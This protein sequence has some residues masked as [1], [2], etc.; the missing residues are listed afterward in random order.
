MMMMTVMTVI[1]FSSFIINVLAQQLFGRLQVQHSNVT[2]CTANNNSQ[3]QTHRKIIRT[4]Q[5]RLKN[6]E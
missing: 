6:Y 3:I 4:K 5:I 1:K 2:E